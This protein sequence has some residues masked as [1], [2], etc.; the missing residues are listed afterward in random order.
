MRQHL[1]I[2][3]RAIILI[4]LV[5]FLAALFLKGF[6]HDILLEAG[7]FLVSVKLIMM[8]YKNSVATAELEVR[9]ENL[10]ATLA[11]ME[12][13]LASGSRETPAAEPR[14]TVNHVG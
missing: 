14:A 13:L 7:V 4:T 11:R 2:W 3:S 10:Q 5:L 12:R 9:F 8:A 1:D 6:G